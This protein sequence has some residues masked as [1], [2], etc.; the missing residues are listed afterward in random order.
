MLLPTAVGYAVLGSARI[1]R[2][3]SRWT[4]KRRRPVRAEEPLEQL[5]ARLRRLRSELEATECRT[6]LTAKGTRLRALRGA[7]LDTLAAAC[8]RTGLNPPPRL[9]RVPQAEIYR[10]EAALRER[11]VDVRDP[12]QISGLGENS[13]VITTTHT[14]A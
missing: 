8:C 13:W 1:P 11:G 12:A 2:W 14:R 5:T 7:Y 10:A 9:G 6:D 3:A 4:G